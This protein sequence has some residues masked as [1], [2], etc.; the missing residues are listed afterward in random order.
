MEMTLSETGLR[1]FVLLSDSFQIGV[2]AYKP[3]LHIANKR[4]KNGQWSW[5]SVI[6]FL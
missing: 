6:E 4:K 1:K 3:T 5:G 2:V